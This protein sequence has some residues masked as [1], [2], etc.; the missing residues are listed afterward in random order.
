MGLGCLQT[1]AK[2]STGSRVP[3]GGDSNPDPG[4][5]NYSDMSE[6]SQAFRPMGDYFS[7]MSE[8][9]LRAFGRRRFVRR[10]IAL[11]TS[12][13]MTAALDDG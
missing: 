9:L 5:R 1:A 2:A 4:G 8:L 6:Q 13:L 11:M 7:D 10:E 12:A 3:G